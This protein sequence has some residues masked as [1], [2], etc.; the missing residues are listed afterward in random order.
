MLE[1]LL[2]IQKQQKQTKKIME[3]NLS[4]MDENIRVVDELIRSAQLRNEAVGTVGES[5]PLNE[6]STDEPEMLTCGH[7]AKF[8]VYATFRNYCAVCG[9][10]ASPKIVRIKNES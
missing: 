2:K 1:E 3:E 4:L 9:E 6:L 8:L 5:I 10:T 7:E